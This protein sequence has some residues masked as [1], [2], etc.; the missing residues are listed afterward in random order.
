MDNPLKQY[1]R[2]PALFISLP[3][4]GKYYPPGSLENT[5]SCE[6]PVFPMTAIDEITAKTPDAL[7]NGSAVVDIIKSCIPNIK[8]PWS[9]PVMDLDPLLISIRAATNSNEMDVNSI[10]PS[11]NEEGKYSVN[12]IGLLNNLD[13]G[14]Y[15]DVVNIDE[16]RDRKSHV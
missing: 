2:R 10:C 11:C 13:S 4:K 3:S 1:F 8:D 9:I 12:L 16:L 14:N 15:D 6:L 7:F 5:D